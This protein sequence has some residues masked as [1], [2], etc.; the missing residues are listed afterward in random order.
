MIFCPASNSSK[1]IPRG[2]VGM[3]DI[4]APLRNNLPAIRLQVMYP[5]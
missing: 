4:F 5:F 3:G 1:Y 2:P